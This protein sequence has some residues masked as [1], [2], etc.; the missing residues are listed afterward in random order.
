MTLTPLDIAHQQMEAAPDDQTASLRFYER[1]ADSE[2]FLMLETDAADD[3]AKP[4]IFE[5]GDG[6]IALVFD[7]EERLAE[8]FESPTP[9]VALSGRRIARLLA[10][11]GIG[12]GVN[13]G[14][15]PSSI[16]LPASAVSWLQETLGAHSVVT[17]AVP[18]EVAAPRGLPESL[19]TAIDTKLANTAGV[20]ARAFLVA[21]KYEGGTKGHML[22]LVDVPEAAKDGVAE[23]LGE[24]LQFSGIEAGQLDLAFLPLD[25]TILPAISRVGLGFEIPELVL[26]KAP[27]PL[28]PGMD[29]ENP[30][31]LR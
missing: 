30:P 9:F 10:G 20:V 23:A 7:R 17:E 11:Q 19:L 8:F 29:P 28:A 14:V 24:V 16:L 3:R 27:K 18:V 12:I 25:S 4:M 15:A 31:K 21:V 2:L 5:T 1:L 26:P 22:A 6:P 13:L